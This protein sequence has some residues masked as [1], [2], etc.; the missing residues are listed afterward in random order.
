MAASHFSDCACGR[1]GREGEGAGVPSLVCV[2]VCV[3]VCVSF[4]HGS[5]DSSLMGVHMVTESAKQ[6]STNSPL[7]CWL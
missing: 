5:K 7:Q 2:C 3:C 1:K 4:I 6:C